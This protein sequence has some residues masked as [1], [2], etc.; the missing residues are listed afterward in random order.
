[1]GEEDRLS[2]CKRL[3]IRNKIK[4]TSGFILHLIVDGKLN[5][6]DYFHYYLVSHW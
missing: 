5:K 4:M 6:I 3:A 2:F 1:M